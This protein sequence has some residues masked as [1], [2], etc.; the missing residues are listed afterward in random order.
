MQSPLQPQQ[1]YQQNQAH[2]SQLNQLLYQ[3]QQLY[4][5]NQFNPQQQIYQQN[6]LSPQQ[7]QLYLQQQQQLNQLN[8]AQQFYQKNQPNQQ[9]FQQ[10]QQYNPQPPLYDPNQPGFYNKDSLFN[11]QPLQ[12]QFQQNK[13]SLQNLLADSLFL[14][15][16]NIPMREWDP[17]IDNEKT[18]FNNRLNEKEL[19]FG[20][21]NWYLREIAKNNEFYRKSNP[22]YLN[23]FA[24]PDVN[25]VESYRYAKVWWSNE[26]AFVK[27]K[28]E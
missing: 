8:E 11:Q 4:P 14:S 28:Q 15:Q 26:S 9:L 18:N 10:G 13:Q 7:L 1:L 3:Q 17:L 22:N 20:F 12:Q 25:Y 2:Q 19:Q 5:K 24:L 21:D 27:D 23:P 6:Q 16:A